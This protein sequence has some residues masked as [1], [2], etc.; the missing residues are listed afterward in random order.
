MD[1]WETFCALCG[2][3]TGYHHDVSLG[4]QDPDALNR[5]REV[6][7]KRQLVLKGGG[8]CDWDELTISD[9]QDESEGGDKETSHASYEEDGG[10]DPELVDNDRTWLN[11]MR[12]LAFNEHSRVD[13]KSVTPAV[14]SRVTTDGLRRAW[15]SGRGT[16]SRRVCFQFDSSVSSCSPRNML[17]RWHEIG[18]ICRPPHNWYALL[19][20]QTELEKSLNT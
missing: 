1:D 10:Y 18:A 7:R 3:S 4:C 8:L 15:L 17:I 6:V 13:S 20:I 12:C 9:L 2:S 14:D 19:H 11:N 16:A 5:R